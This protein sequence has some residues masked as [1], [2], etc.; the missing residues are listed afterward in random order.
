[1]DNCIQKSEQK[2]YLIINTFDL[3]EQRWF[4]L[5]DVSPNGTSQQ[6]QRHH[7]RGIE[8]PTAPPARRPPHPPLLG[9]MEAV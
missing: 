2:V 9:G 1:M 8:H 6:T 7:V 5:Y 3:I 4:S